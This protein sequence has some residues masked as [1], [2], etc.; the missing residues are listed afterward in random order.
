MN[1]YNNPKGIILFII[2]FLLWAYFPGKSCPCNEPTNCVRREF[3]GIQLNHFALYICIGFIFPSYFWTFFFLGVIW[4]LLEYVLDKNPNWVVNYIG[5]CL[6]DPPLNHS[7]INRVDNPLH[8]YIV[9]K[10]VKKP[11]HPIDTFFGIENS[12]IHGWHGSPAELLPNT[13]GFAIGFLI[14]KTIFHYL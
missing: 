8:N 10:G 4:E 3:Y 11:L 12:T 13:I 1:L 9:Y 2:G 14:N 7:Y 6:K 5:G